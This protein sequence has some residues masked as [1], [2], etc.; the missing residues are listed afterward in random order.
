MFLPLS[1]FPPSSRSKSNL[2]MS[3]DEDKKKKQTKNKK[4]HP[5]LEGKKFLQKPQILMLYS[6]LIKKLELANKEPA[7]H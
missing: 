1:L 5:L 7:L 6:A 3:L 4:W 2:K